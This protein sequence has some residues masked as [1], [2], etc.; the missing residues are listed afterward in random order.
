M[1]EKIKRLVQKPILVVLASLILFFFWGNPLSM[2]IIVEYSFG[3]SVLI[4]SSLEDIGLGLMIFIPFVLYF[5]LMFALFGTAIKDI[6]TNKRLS[7]DSAFQI[8]WCVI[9][10]CGPLYVFLAMRS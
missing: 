4:P 8:V 1:I 9:M 7:S 6:Q 3:S 10:I 2:L 5:V